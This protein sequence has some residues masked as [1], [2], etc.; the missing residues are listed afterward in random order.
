MPLVIGTRLGPYEVGYALVMELVEGP[1]L[2]EML[3]GSGLQAPGS[4]AQAA[5]VPKPVARSLK[6]DEALAIA[7]QIADALDAA[8]E[9]GI[10]HRDL[11]PAD[12][13]PLTVVFNWTAGL[14]AK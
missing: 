6:P 10:V 14:A 11:K 12:I 2:A 13:K 3:A 9:K 8:H 4:G 5:G 7:R 1:T